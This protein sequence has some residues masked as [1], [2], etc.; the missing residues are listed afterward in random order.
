MVSDFDGTSLY[1]ALETESAYVERCAP[2]C[3]GL[4]LVLIG[5]MFDLLPGPKVLGGDCEPLH[6]DSAM[7]V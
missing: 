7:S 4:V 2:S 3:W 5:V 6:F 1:I